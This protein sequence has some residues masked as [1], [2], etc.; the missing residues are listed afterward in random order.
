M[1]RSGSASREAA[2]TPA[3]PASPVVDAQAWQGEATESPEGGRRP[4]GRMRGSPVQEES[5]KPGWERSQAGPLEGRSS[6]EIATWW[7]YLFVRSV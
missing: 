2:T 1:G 5:M 6:D 4:E 7:A 3:Q